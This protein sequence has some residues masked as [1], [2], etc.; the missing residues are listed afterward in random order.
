MDGGRAVFEGDTDELADG[1]A[2]LLDRA[3]DQYGLTRYP[4]G[5][6]VGWLR[7]DALDRPSLRDPGNIADDLSPFDIE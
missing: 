5:A 7:P 6:N 1:A 2:A 3:A 4:D